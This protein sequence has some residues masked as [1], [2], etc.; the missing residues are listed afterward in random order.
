MQAM[1]HVFEYHV[2]AT[3][4]SMK[5]DATPTLTSVLPSRAYL[6][7]RSFD[8]RLFYAHKDL[9]SVYDRVSPSLQCRCQKPISRRCV[10]R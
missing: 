7:A 10:V 2:L 8:M 3:L 4:Y 1:I 9:C 6:L 5:S